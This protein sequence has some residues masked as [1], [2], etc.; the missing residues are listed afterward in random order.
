MIHADF[1]LLLVSITNDPCFYQTI[2][3]SHDRQ[4]NCILSIIKYQALFH[5]ISRHCVLLIKIWNCHLIVY[6]TSHTIQTFYS[7][8]N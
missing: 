6:N 7:L 8:I 5:D 4:N 1:I 2:D 3:E